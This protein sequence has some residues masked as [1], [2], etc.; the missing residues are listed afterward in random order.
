MPN[1]PNSHMKPPARLTI[2]LALFLLAFA[3]AHAMDPALPTKAAAMEILRTKKEIPVAFPQGEPF[4]LSPGKPEGPEIEPLRFQITDTILILQ[5]N[6]WVPFDLRQHGLTL[7]LFYAAA[8]SAGMAPYLTIELSERTSDAQLAELLKNLQERA[9]KG[10]EKAP[11][12]TI[13]LRNGI[14]DDS[15]L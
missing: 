12:K 11:L 3:P 9:I 10:P 8:K 5:G 15:T 4:I 14:P 7:D 1:K 2:A 6:D 13:Y